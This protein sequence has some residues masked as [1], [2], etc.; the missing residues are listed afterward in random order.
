MPCYACSRA[1]VVG[2]RHGGCSPT[3]CAWLLLLGVRR[4]TV[5]LALLRSFLHS[6]HLPVDQVPGSEPDLSP[7]KALFA[8]ALIV[9]AMALI[10]TLAYLLD[11]C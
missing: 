11:R 4:I 3:A 8:G 5:T 1:K 2:K 7:S 10:V 9:F 6:F